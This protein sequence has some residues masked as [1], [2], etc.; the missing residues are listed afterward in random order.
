MNRVLPELGVAVLSQEILDVVARKPGLTER[1]LADY[2]YGRN[3]FEQ[4][5]KDACCSLVEQ[6]RL[7]RHG[8]GHTDDPFTYYPS[9]L[10]SH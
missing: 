8:H 4:H 1:D 10:T 9:K 6:G 5:L 7:E 3:K 2:F